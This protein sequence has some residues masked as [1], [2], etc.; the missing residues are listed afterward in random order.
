MSKLFGFAST[1]LVIAAGIANNQQFAK[2][3]SVEAYEIR[4]GV[5]AMPKYTRD[6][7]PCEVGLEKLHYTHERVSLDSTLSN[8]IVSQI[9]DELVS[10]DEKRSR[11]IGPG[12]MIASWH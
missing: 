10:P 8:Q 9:V 3:P 1:A 7:R 11:I 5:L 6:G 12:T 2:Y 4:P